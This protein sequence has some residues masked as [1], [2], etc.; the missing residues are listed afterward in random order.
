MTFILIDDDKVIRDAWEK[1]ARAQ[2]VILISYQRAADFLS[3]SNLYQKEIEIYIDTDLDEEDSFKWA[4]KIYELG[5]QKIY[6]LKSILFEEQKTLPEFASG[7]FSKK[8][9]F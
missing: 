9:P 3:D 5:F 7:L 6:F 4:R 2:G 1:K 8:P